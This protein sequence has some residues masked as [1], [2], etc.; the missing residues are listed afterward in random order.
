LPVVSINLNVSSFIAGT[1]E[2]VNAAMTPTV[3]PDGTYSVQLQANGDLSTPGT[4]YIV[5]EYFPSGAIYSFTIIV[6]QTAGPFVMSNLITPPAPAAIVNSRVTTLV[7]DGT[8]GV[9]I[10]AAGDVAGRSF[11]ASANAPYIQTAL[12]GGADIG[13]TRIGGPEPWIDVTAP[14]VKIGATTYTLGAKYDG[15]TDDTVAHQNLRAALNITAADA[16][17]G[18]P[19]WG[20]GRL[21]H[22]VTV[23]SA[24]IGTLTN[25]RSSL[26]G[27]GVEECMLKYTGS[28][29][30]LRV[31][32]N[33]F[34]NVPASPAPFS[35]GSRLKGFAID[36]NGAAAGAVGLQFGDVV[37][38]E[39]DLLVQHFN[40]AG[41]VGVWLNNVTNFT[42]RNRIKLAIADCTT[43][44]KFSKDDTNNATVSFGYSEF[45]L[46]FSTSAANQKCIQFVS[47][48]GASL[49]LYNPRIFAMANLVANSTFIDLGTSNIAVLDGLVDLRA[50]GPASCT[51][52]NISAAAEWRTFG[53]MVNGT[54]GIVIPNAGTG[55]V[56]GIHFGSGFQGGASPGVS[57][58]TVT[59][60]SNDG[61]I[62][63]QKLHVNG[64]G[65]VQDPSVKHQ[66]DGALND[67]PLAF[68]YTPG[69]ADAKM[70]DWVLSANTLAFRLTNDAY[71]AATNW[72][73]V[74]R[75]GIAIS[76]ITFGATVTTPGLTVND[77]NNG[78]VSAG[79]STGDLYLRSIAA[80]YVRLNDQ[81][82]TNVGVG[83]ATGTVGFY[84]S[85]GQA[86]AAA[87]VTLADVIAIIRGTGLSA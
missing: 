62:E 44:L 67:V 15:V 33:P 41:S 18:W 87:P 50:E 4:W 78:L 72:L 21:G 70:W 68:K 46:Q 55:V 5:T 37:G 76:S 60:R 85:N 82:G 77:G 6:P 25:Y 29:T 54:T 43:C 75:A 49:S 48:A 81:A 12:A 24:A 22:G 58:L 28:G 9:A 51:F 34:T 7:V 2:I 35:I 45:D 30:C 16:A 53:V 47:A 73:T 56:E 17:S 10:N 14:S 61:R 1:Q 66:I 63:T 26:F 36:G 8:S 3:A 13:P 83:N 84:G 39:L 80:R 74:V 64:T 57:V 52:I 71:G 27:P 40:G 20:R 23:I 31:Q 69:G 42:E 79:G 65:A 59:G 11:T 38:G 19:G 86:R 32:E